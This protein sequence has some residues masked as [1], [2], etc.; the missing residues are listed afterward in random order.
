[1]PRICAAVL[2]FAAAPLS[3][4]EPAGVIPLERFSYEKPEFAIE[5]VNDSTGTTFGKIE[6]DDM[7]SFGLRAY[8]SLRDCAIALSYD[9]FT[10]RGDDPATA[11]RS[12]ELSLTAAWLGPELGGGIAIARFGAGA[13]FRAWGD[14]GFQATQE[15]WHSFLGV[16]RPFPTAQAGASFRPFAYATADIAIRGGFPVEAAIAI[17]ELVL[18][19][20]GLESSVALFISR[21]D[22][23]SANGLGLSRQDRLGSFDR[24]DSL[25]AE[26]EEGTW[27]VAQAATG[28]LSLESA[29]NLDTNFAMAAIALRFGGDASS[30][31]AA[32]PAS[33]RQELTVGTSLLDSALATSRFLVFDPGVEIHAGIEA[34][35]GVARFL[36]DEL[37]WPHYQELSLAAEVFAPGRDSVLRLAP[38]AGIAAGF[39]EDCLAYAELERSELVQSSKGFLVKAYAGLRLFDIGIAKDRG[40][41]IALDAGLGLSLVAKAFPPPAL[42]LFLRA[43]LCD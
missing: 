28:L 41:R 10:F 25:A 19:S 8:G 34:V 6:T 15:Y 23:L 38:F 36:W 32:E 21:R 14:F 31:G 30:R 37:G 26:Y 33:P 12:D 5:T 43:S 2:T 4:L 3:A 7:R 13:G 39:R 40:E 27:L 9:G 18:G 17:R 24:N 42:S 16:M 11:T 29:V 22:G 35:S 20:D 1:L